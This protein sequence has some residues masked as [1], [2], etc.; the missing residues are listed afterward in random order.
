MVKLSIKFVFVVFSQNRVLRPDTHLFGLKTAV[1]DIST[2]FPQWG[3]YIYPLSEVAPGLLVIHIQIQAV[4]WNIWLFWRK[5]QTYHCLMMIS[6]LDQYVF[7]CEIW[8]DYEDHQKKAFFRR[9][10]IHHTIYRF[11]SM[12]WAQ[13][14]SV[15]SR[16]F[17][18]NVFT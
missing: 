3:I 11:R 12:Q 6:H 17:C 8:L 15:V 9:I 5:K 14:V 4:C 2:Q 1:F 10:S 18:L 7:H 13:N 16:Y